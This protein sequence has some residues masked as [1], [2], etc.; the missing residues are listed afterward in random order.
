MV[1]TG[2][3]AGDRR[4]V[5]RYSAVLQ[6][7]FLGWWH[8]SS[9]TNVPGRLVDL[10]VSG[11][12]LEL[13]RL[14]PLAPAQAVWVHLHKESQIEWIEGQIIAIRKPLLRKCE[15]RVS[16]V[17]T[18]SYEPF[19]KVIYGPGY[20]QDHVKKPAPEHEWDQFWK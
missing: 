1:K 7:A 8:E 11:C 9:F 17:E 10:S 18:L 20:L 3:D 19:K 14:P 15:V 6:K 4:R 13:D 16:F 12:R 5:C 2:P